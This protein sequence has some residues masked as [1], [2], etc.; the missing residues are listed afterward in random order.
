MNRQLKIIS[1][2]GYLRHRNIKE[3]LLIFSWRVF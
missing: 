1:Q 2:I 3:F